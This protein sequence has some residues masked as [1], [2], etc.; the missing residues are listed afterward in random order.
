[1]A[2]RN[3]PDARRTGDFGVPEYLRRASGDFAQVILWA[4]DYE[5]L[6]HDN[7]RVL[8]ERFL[9]EIRKYNMLEASELRSLFGNTEELYASSSK[10]IHTLKSLTSAHNRLDMVIALYSTDLLPVYRT[11]CEHY[12]HA[13]KAFSRLLAKNEK[14]EGFIN[15]QQRQ[16]SVT[17]ER[18]LRQP[19]DHVSAYY[20]VIRKVQSCT[21][22]THP[23]RPRLD[24]IL[25]HWGRLLRD[26]EEA[27]RL[28][29]NEEKLAAIELSFPDDD[30]QLLARPQSPSH[31]AAG[32]TA[33]AGAGQAAGAGAGDEGRVRTT[34]RRLSAPSA[35]FKFVTQKDSG[36]RS[37]G[38]TRFHHSVT[39][40]AA[41]SSGGA[42]AQ[43]DD[44]PRMFVKEGPAMLLEEDGVT[45]RRYLF[46][47]NDVL[48]IAK[49]RTRGTYSL[50][51]RLPLKQL[52]MLPPT[53]LPEG[54]GCFGLG[55]FNPRSL[56]F[57]SSDHV[58][59]I[60][61]LERSLQL[62]RASGPMHGH[63]NVFAI[64]TDVQPG[65]E[66]E[67]QME[68]LEVSVSDTANQVVSAAMTRLSVPVDARRY[69]LW[70]LTRTGVQP[71]QSHEPPLVIAQAGAAAQLMDDAC[72]F[73][74]R[75]VAT[76]L[77]MDLLP[78]FLRRIVR[79]R[80]PSVVKKI[81]PKLA[82]GRSVEAP[83]AST[84]ERPLSSPLPPTTGALFGQP[85][86]SI[87]VQ[88][89]LPPPI[90]AMLARLA[91][92]GPTAPGL[93][94]KSANARVIKQLRE[95][96]DTGLPVDFSAVPV[97]A[98]GAI[99][100]EFL[101][102][103]PTSLFPEAKYH[104][105]IAINSITDEVVRI[106]AL[107]AKLQELPEA[108]MLLLT[109]VVHVLIAI[110]AN[111]E[112]NMMTA[113]NLAVCVGQSLMW[114][115]TAEEVLKN[116]VPPFIEFLITRGPLLFDN[117]P[118]PPQPVAAVEINTHPPHVFSVREESDDVLSPLTPPPLAPPTA[119]RSI[120]TAALATPL[121]SPPV[122]PRSTPT[123]S[124]FA[125]RRTRPDGSSPVPL[126]HGG[127]VPQ[128]PS[129]H[130]SQY[131]STHPL[132]LTPQ[133]HPH[134]HAHPYQRV[135]HSSL[136]PSPLPLASR[137]YTPSSPSPVPLGLS[138]DARLDGLTLD[139]AT[140]A[141]PLLAS[142]PPR[143][144]KPS[145][146]SMPMPPLPDGLHSPS[147]MSDSPGPSTSP[148]RFQSPPP[149]TYTPP[150]CPPTAAPA[151]R[152]QPGTEDLVTTLV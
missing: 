95:R 30:L 56:F 25:Q 38:K 31:S 10:L 16:T 39:G 1:M 47:F 123:V 103:L 67:S 51:H 131:T 138:L 125:R 79:E 137:S 40:Q 142:N 46:L 32:P 82:K 53:A 133:A 29:E 130:S 92:E 33:S 140:G 124:P 98:I 117:L 50:K 3:S 85:L 68:T 108:H 70:E 101:R 26:L 27:R 97:L 84:P 28:R 120:W 19:V 34:T 99:L 105:L 114:P 145:Q 107:R 65:P 24:E 115:P 54:E 94:R 4:L 91:I 87:L 109:A 71:L 147:E 13:E 73:V 14:F 135:S 55:S 76:D 81:F 72:H 15:V 22:D 49:A 110:A 8:V 134:H 148:F 58:S 104:E 89:D 152:R 146:Q 75:P 102:A 126:H 77:P 23:G 136:P 122:S 127:G 106:S 151:P 78:D 59:W 48:F 12:P 139:G 149:P 52:W 7:L 17:L 35:L 42:H 9:N 96:L 57:S 141:D 45:R 66:A 5:T 116:E 112:E 128:S 86:S 143:H 129:Q 11:Y 6:Y 21:A 88:G 150:T 111:H 64:L 100:K 121:P 43:A 132:A 118:E 83:L 69:V 63:V 44:T 80:S 90:R 36:K 18:L 2:E 61:T 74:L 37:L 62:V 41:M 60:E 144:R 119:P 20:E 93:F 113:G